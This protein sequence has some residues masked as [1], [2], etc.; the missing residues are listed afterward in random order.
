[1]N[2]AKLK[3]IITFGLPLICLCVGFVAGVYWKHSENIRSLTEYQF[4]HDDTYLSSDLNTISALR[5]G[6]VESTISDL[7]Y[8]ALTRINNMATNKALIP[9]IYSGNYKMVSIEPL[10]K[11]MEEYPSSDLVHKGNAAIT[12]IINKYE[13]TR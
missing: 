1:M 13:S 3:R 10:H 5:D 12:E 6:K 9:E 4:I 11:Y 2:V 8:V 7:E